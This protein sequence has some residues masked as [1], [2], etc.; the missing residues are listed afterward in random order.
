MSVVV[1][2]NDG[3]LFFL[4]NFRPAAFL[5]P[6]FE[7]KTNSFFIF[8]QMDSQTKV[9]SHAGKRMLSFALSSAVS[10]NRKN[11]AHRA[12]NKNPDKLTVAEKEALQ[13]IKVSVWQKCS[14]K[15]DKSWDAYLAKKAYEQRSIKLVDVWQHCSDTS[16]NSWSNYAS[17]KDNDWKYCSK[18]ESWTKT[19][20]CA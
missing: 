19:I 1:K 6:F 12:K 9:V 15:S 20:D 10:H 14:D 4:Q 7:I 13:A 2:K 18:K 16:D 11:L 17:H 5:F 8:P 3:F